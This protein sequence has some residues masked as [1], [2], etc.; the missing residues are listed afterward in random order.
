M[1]QDKY[2]AGKVAIVTGASKLSGIGAAAAI[3]LAEHGA[4][5]AVHYSSNAA[6]AQEVV[7][8]IKS[9]GVQATAIKADASSP[10]FGTTLVA[11][12]L[13]AFNT[14]NID[15][16]VNNAGTAVMHDSAASVPADVWDDV[17]RVNVRGPFLL[18]QAALPHMKSGGRIVNTSSIIAKL[19][20]SMLPVYGASKGALN[21]MSIALAEELG[22]KGITINL[23]S[24]GP[25]KTDLSMQGSPVAAR[26]ERNQHIKREGSTEEV[27]AA[28]LFLSSPTS[29]YITGQNLYYAVSRQTFAVLVLQIFRDYKSNRVYGFK[30][31]EFQQPLEAGAAVL[32]LQTEE[33]KMRQATALRPM[34]ESTE[35]G[36]KYTAVQNRIVRL[37]AQLKAVTSGQSVPTKGKGSASETETPQSESPLDCSCGR[38]IFNTNFSI[39]YDSGIHW[40]DLFPSLRELY[41]QASAEAESKWSQEKRGPV[42]IG[43]VSPDSLALAKYH[44]TPGE[45]ELLMSIF[46][47]NVNPFVRVLNKNAFQSDMQRYRTG[48]HP[49]PELVDSLLFS[50]YGLAVM[51]LESQNA[52]DMFGLPKEWLLDKYQEAQEIA[53]HRLNFIHSSEP[54]VFQ[55]FLYYLVFLFERGSYRTAT[56]LLGL[57]VRIAQRIGLHKDPS[58][59]SYSPWMSEW[60]RRLWNQLIL[61][62]QRAVAFDGTQSLLSFP[63]DTQLPLNADD[64]AWNTSLFMKPS[65]IPSPTQDF[66]D[67]TPILVKR[68]VLSILCPV[69][70]KIRTRPYPQQVQHIEAGFKEATHFFQSVGTDKQGLANFVQAVCEIEFGN[71][72]LMAGQAVVRSGSAN[73]EFLSQLYLESLALL[74]R[75]ASVRN[76]VPNPGWLWY[77]RTSPP[78]FAIAITLTHLCSEPANCHSER[79]WRQINSFFDEYGKE[80]GT[81]QSASMAALQS[82]RETAML[83]SGFPADR[84]A[85]AYS[86]DQYLLQSPENMDTDYLIQPA[87]DLFSDMWSNSLLGGSLPTI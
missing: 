22:P 45:A 47:E 4:N 29:G 34:Q 23:V 27:A 46:F 14:S 26:L 36:A 50:I 3:A 87:A 52:V 85:V 32:S 65:E 58:W 13:K 5:I 33:D 62:E 1:A 24:P 64:G 43:A 48:K 57:A 53:L 68:H 70:Q 63:W 55:N 76:S 12:T 80:N 59:F 16:L 67:M 56:T 39:H 74:E 18:I 41:F 51:S 69:R 66:T 2:L 35:D 78:V 19:G 73:S 31:G 25:I 81:I 7:E 21:S 86:D 6:S 83:S 40:V 75:I 38:Q 28:I 17:F 15:I 60:R 71:L 37:E 72:R 30:Y 42:L 61:L 20:S 44:P 84:P 8:K 54:A 82:L 79:A 10:D 9:L 49:Q 11:G 77:L